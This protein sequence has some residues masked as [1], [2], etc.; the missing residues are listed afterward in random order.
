MTAADIIHGAIA[1]LESSGWRKGSGGSPYGRGPCCIAHA[2]LRAEANSTGRPLEVAE[3]DQAF[4]RVERAISRDE[5]SS[6][7]LLNSAGRV[8]LWNDFHCNDRGQAIALLQ[9][10]LPSEAV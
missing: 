9:R 7:S 4:D 8:M 6:S 10:A 3:L 2:L 1:E 5:L